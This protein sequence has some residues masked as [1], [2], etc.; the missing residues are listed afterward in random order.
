MVFG[1]WVAV[2]PFLGFPLSW[3]K[4]LACLSGLLIIVLAYRLKPENAAKNDPA[5]TSY[6]EHRSVPIAKA[7]K[8]AGVDPADTMPSIDKE[9]PLD[10]AVV[11]SMPGKGTSS[12]NAITDHP[13]GSQGQAGGSVVQ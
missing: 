5:R 11:K 12:E 10:F 2:L 13:N 9:A 1:V 6:A 3:E 4:F 8:E 7:P